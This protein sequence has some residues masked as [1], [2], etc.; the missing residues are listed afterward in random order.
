MVMKTG[1]TVTSSTYNDRFT[2]VFFGFTQCR[3]VCPLGLNLMDSIL[4]EM[5][6]KGDDLVP[7]F[8]TIDPERDSA[9]RIKEYLANF[10]ERIVGLHGS[11]DALAQAR[12]AFRIE[13]P[14]MEIKSKLDYQFDH[15]A[16]MMLMDKQGAYLRSIPSAGDPKELANDLLT[17]MNANQ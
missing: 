2:L 1:N 17:A 15:P 16:L 9:E 7:I 3:V 14:R 13:A 5:G 11:P 12:K 6:D 10:H 8:I 4:T